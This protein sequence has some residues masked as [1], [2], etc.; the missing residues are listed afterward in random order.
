MAVVGGNN[1]GQLEDCWC[2][3]RSVIELLE[4]KKRYGGYE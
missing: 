1:A 2:W 3:R 4:A